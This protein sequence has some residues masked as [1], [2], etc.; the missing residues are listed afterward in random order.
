MR[1]KLYRAPG[2]AEALVHVRRELGAEAIILRTRRVS[3]GV[4]VTAAIE[5]ESPEPPFPAT[6]ARAGDDARDAA[7]AWHGVPLGVAGKL[8]AGPLPFALSIAYRFGALDFGQAAPPVAFI[9]PP[10]AGKTLT[11]ARLATRLVLAGRMPLVV[12][13]DGKR[14]GATEQLAAFTRLLGLN[15]LVASAPPAIGRALARRSEGAPVLI[16]MPG[17]DVFDRAQSEDLAA[18]ISAAGACSAAVLPG[19]LDPAEAAEISSAFRELGAGDLVATRLDVTRR[20][21]STLA[22][23]SAGLALTE[24]GIGPGAADGLVRLTP[25]YLAAR[26]LHIPERPA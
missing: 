11:V 4:E 16:D 17:I 22:A 15:L 20:L 6:D 21:G 2:I 9:G 3:E 25:E 24:A 1:L 13:A 5:E 10:G 19:G 18:L 8:A 14:A 26:L 7:L 23:A 12:T